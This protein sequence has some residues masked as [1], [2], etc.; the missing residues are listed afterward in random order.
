MQYEG[1]EQ[2]ELVMQLI[3]NELSEPYSIFTYRYVARHACACNTTHCGRA[4]TRC[5]T[6]LQILP[7]QL[8][9]AVLLGL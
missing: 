2:I 6:R 7:A 3:D 5:R 1:E 9:V 8:A 4:L